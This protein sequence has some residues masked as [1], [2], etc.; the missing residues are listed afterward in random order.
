[1]IEM[2][3][4]GAALRA[5][6]RPRGSDPGSAALCARL[7]VREYFVAD[8][9]LGTR[10]T[11][12]MI[13]KPY[14]QTGTEVSAIG[15]GGMRF[16][17]QNDV[18]GCATLV[19]AAYDA[20]INYFDTA[21]GYGKSEELFGVAFKE[22]LPTRDERPFYVSTK[23]MQ[24]EPGEIR[25]ELETSLQRMGLDA[26][27]FY[28][29]WCVLSL[30]A[31]HERKAKGALDEFARLRDEGLV[32]H[33]CV[34]TH[35]T[36]DD[37]GTM[38]DE[39]P[40]EGIL[41]GYSVMNFPY[42]ER[43]VEAAADKGMGVVVM[44]PLGGGI[45]PGNPHRFEFV[46]TREDEDVVD[47]ALRFLINDPRITVA[48][49]GLSDEKQ[50]ADAIT[51]VD[52]FEPIPPATVQRIRDTLKDAYNELCTGCRYCDSCPEGVPVP[53]LMD[54]YNH[55]V[56]NEGEQHALNRLRWHWGIQPDDPVLDACIE[57]GRC[58]ELCT[59]KLPII[60]RL[61]ALRGA[62]EKAR[63]EAKE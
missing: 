30:D 7:S 15:F 54:A 50:L 59:Q 48:L 12:A 17:D 56:L 5:R 33:V 22:M 45:I 49:V 57:C 31:F 43:G 41:L 28:H 44:N 46:R 6:Q 40:F 9:A 8:C 2:V 63:E 39:Y 55:W 60:E 27:D 52:G 61:R 23:T 25:R 47:G 19:K 38:L 16:R 3:F 18:D 24:A 35:M 10:R 4:G 32:K 29:V 20:G 11:A 53:K 14:G 58:E 13:Y 26:V 34:S 51:A 37:I 62:A 42:R 1:M 36:G 21:I